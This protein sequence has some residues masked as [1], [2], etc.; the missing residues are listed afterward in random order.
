MRMS[1]TKRTDQDTGFPSKVAAEFQVGR[2]PADKSKNT[3]P[4]QTTETRPSSC[5]SQIERAYNRLQGSMRQVAESLLRAPHEYVGKSISKVAQDSH[6][7]DATVLRFVRSIGYSGFRSFALALATSVSSV[8]ASDKELTL[9]I[10]ERDNLDVIVKKVFEA[11]SKALLKAP[12]TLGSELVRRAVMALAKARWVYTYAVGSSGFL[13]GEAEYRLAR[14]GIRCT[15]IHDPIQMAIQASWLTSKDVVIGFSQTG[16][17]RASV[18]GLQLARKSG[19]TTIGI[20]SKP[21]SPL[22]AASDIPLVLFEL[23][24]VFHGAF[25][26]SKI[27]EL[28]LID[29]LAT[30]IAFRRKSR[31]EDRNRV[32]LAIEQMLI[33]PTGTRSNSK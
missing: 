31:R 16:R 28:T 33:K 18:E 20:T 9:G 11:E 17:N 6:V 14:L 24:A 3:I 25:L 1:S 22:S 2:T 19:A 32:D 10:S 30:C 27:A 21:G 12:Q 15:A 8:P 5:V 4:Q 13:A 7:S 23:S 29:A 26:D